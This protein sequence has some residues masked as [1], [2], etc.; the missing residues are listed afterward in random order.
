MSLS[1]APTIDYSSEAYRQA[2][3]LINGVVIMGE[4]HADH[5]FRLLAD[6]IPADREKLLALAAMEA[7]HAREFVGCGRNLQV[8]ANIPLARKLFQPLHDSLTSALE[9]GELVRPLVIQGLIIECFAIAAY[10]CYLPVADPYA[11]GITT[12]VIDDEHLHLNY[13]EQWLQRN[14]SSHREEIAEACRRELPTTLTILRELWSNLEAIG[15]APAGLV[16]E[17]SG[18]FNDS[19]GAIGFQPKEAMAISTAALASALA[20]L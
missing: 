6:A 18:L 8:Q 7:R 17:F 19:L 10:H 11:K 9:Q 2:Y 5:H 3:A 1:P 15:I 20:H 13:G 12:W 4:N 16:A 14:F